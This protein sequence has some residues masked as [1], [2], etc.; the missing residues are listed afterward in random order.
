MAD[1]TKAYALTAA[2]E[3]GYVDDPEDAGGE[4]YRG[5]SRRYHPSWQGWQI[6]D[7]LKNRFCF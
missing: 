3:G 5:I 1:F 7:T 2:Y 4:T 6:I